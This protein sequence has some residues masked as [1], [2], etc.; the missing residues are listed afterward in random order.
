M[1]KDTK[2][3]KAKVQ[4]KSK[5]ARCRLNQDILAGIYGEARP[6]KLGITS[7]WVAGRVVA[8]AT[9]VGRPFQSGIIRT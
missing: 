3:I 5:G 8:A 4:D 9:E 2:K 6:N 1:L 7:L